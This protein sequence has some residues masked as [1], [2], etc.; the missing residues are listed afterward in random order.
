LLSAEAEA[1]IL[2]NV[3]DWLEWGSAKKLAELAELST[4]LPVDR[5]FARQIA[6]KA[7]H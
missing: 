4:A 6:R 7:K 5:A 2:D 1:E 3:A